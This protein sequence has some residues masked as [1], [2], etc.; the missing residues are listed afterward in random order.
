MQLGQLSDKLHE[1]YQGSCAG[2]ASL[3]SIEFKG[4]HSQT[5][6]NMKVSRINSEKGVNIMNMDCCQS[7][8][9][10]SELSE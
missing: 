9:P 7:K 1:F 2:L 5:W 10:L 8:T 3:K 6:Q 4:M